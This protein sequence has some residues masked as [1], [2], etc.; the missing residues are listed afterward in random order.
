MA[1]D[2]EQTMVMDVPDPDNE[3]PQPPSQESQQT[4]EPQPSPEDSAT[5][6]GL[7]RRRRWALA[8]TVGA[9]LLSGAGVAATAVIKSPAQVA[10][11]TGP[12]P[13]DVLIA[14]VEKRV[15]QETVVLRGTVAAGQSV[16]VTPTAS[17]GEGA[18]PAVV[19][20][21]SLKAGAQIHS[22]QVLVEVSGRPVFV[23][24]G[25]VPSYRDLKPTSTG[26]DV[27]QLQ[28]ALR[29]LG[30]GTG[31]DAS[32]TF[33][34][35][36]KAA[37]KAFYASIGYDPKPAVD[38][39]GAALKSAQDAVLSANRA[40]QDAQYAVDQARTAATSAG[41]ST[42]GAAGGTAGT[43]GAKT[44]GTSAGA[45]AGSSDQHMLNE[46]LSRAKQDR[47]T[48]R[49]TLA[50]AQ[51]AS[52]PMLP[53]GE[54]VYLDS[55][56]ARVDAVSAKVGSTVSGPVMTVS[57]GALVAQGYVQ[58]YQKG[59]VHPGQKVQILSE[60]TGTTATATVE[61]VAAQA[62]VAA[63]TTQG[64]STGQSG[65]DDSGGG[66]AAG[67]SL[68]YL[69]VI[70]PDHKLPAVLSGAD[71]RLT[72]EAA[73][74]NGKALVVPVTAVS[75]GADSRT[76]VTKVDGTG[77]Q[78][79]VEVKTGTTGDGYVEVTPVVAGSLSED[80]NVV[81]GINPGAPKGNP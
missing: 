35:G 64:S 22:G 32:G 23:L 40:V 68:G 43:G 1:E 42:G 60:G 66:S 57:S 15:L 72:I 16:Q 77:R 62:S 17:G 59:L 33:G 25:S 45:G 46:T 30:H 75:A 9:V 51:A 20:K 3:P 28:K 71:I 24:P 34:S 8:I 67:G 55:F 80:D 2:P 13:Q 52:G 41:A 37:L 4:Q 49:S 78:T 47:T 63:G 79:R 19:T 56:P 39:N 7:S 70:K 54:V 6:S 27:A 31:G 18:G 29:G 50:A 76:V 21:L 69:I 10:A 26:Q 53:S 58:D 36:T 5:G 73:S 65:T 44:G 81:T 11:E 48:A 14:R 12:P 38:D 61:S 74:T